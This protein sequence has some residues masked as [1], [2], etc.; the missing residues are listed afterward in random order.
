MDAGLMA[1]LGGSD[2]AQAVKVQRALAERHRHTFMI[3]KQPTNKTRKQ[4][5][6]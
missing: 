3:D 2:S 5:R 1:P 6:P 4:A